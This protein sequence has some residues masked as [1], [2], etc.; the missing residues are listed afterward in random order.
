MAK[1]VLKMGKHLPLGKKLRKAR[2]LAAYTQTDVGELLQIAPS[3][4]S[5]LE[6]FN[7]INWTMAKL[8]QLTSIYRVSFFDLIVDG[9]NKMIPTVD[10]GY[11]VLIDD[12]QTQLYIYRAYIKHILPHVKVKPF[13]DPIKAYNWLQKNKARLIIA[14]HHM[15]G[16]NGGDILT[17][18]NLAGFKNAKTPAILMTD[19]S[20]KEII[21]RIARE[22]NAIFYDKT[23]H[24]DVFRHAV[25]DLLKIV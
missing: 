6:R 21:R 7:A 3:T 8:I 4:I 17:K 13:S 24:K 25:S 14:D 11:V 2:M 22:E 18:I 1:K 9:L 16:L 23:G 19:K 5:K 10:G 20:D 12:E 15:P